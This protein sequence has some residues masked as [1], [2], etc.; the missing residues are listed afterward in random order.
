VGVK[1]LPIGPARTDRAG[2]HLPEATGGEQ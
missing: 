1:G 2:P